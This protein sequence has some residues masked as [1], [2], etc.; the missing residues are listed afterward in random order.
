MKKCP[1]IKIQ[2]IQNIKIYCN[3]IVSNTLVIC[4]LVTLIKLLYYTLNNIYKK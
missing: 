2:K 1:K 4:S 3:N